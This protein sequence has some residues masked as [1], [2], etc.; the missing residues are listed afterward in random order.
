MQLDACIGVGTN[1]RVGVEEAKPEGPRAG[2]GFL[3]EG[4]ASPSPPTR[5]FTGALQ[6]PSAGSVAEPRPPKGFLAF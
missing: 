1:F 4:K 6:A 2:N 5:G 3:G